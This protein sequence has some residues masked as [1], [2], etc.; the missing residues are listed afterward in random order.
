[1]GRPA[2]CREG[3]APDVKRKGVDTGVVQKVRGTNLIILFQREGFISMAAYIY[4]K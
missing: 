4:L 2:K 3:W 1:M